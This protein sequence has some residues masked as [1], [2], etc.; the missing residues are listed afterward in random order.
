MKNL[1]TVALSLI[2]ILVTAFSVLLDFMSIS[3][4]TSLFTDLSYWANIASVNIAIMMII[5]VSRSLAKDRECK[6]YAE[7]K[8]LTESIRSAYKGLNDNRLNTA[9]KQYIQADNRARKLK[10]YTEK[11]NRKIYKKNQVLKR[12]ENAVRR[13]LIKSNVRDESKIKSRIDQV[14]RKT[15]EQLFELEERLNHA[16][17]DVEFLRV[18]GWTK[19]TYSVI[20]GGVEEKEKEEADLCTHESRSVAA[21]ALSKFAG[22]V[23]FGIVATSFIAFDV[24]AF[25]IFTVYKAIL[26]VLQIA[27]GIYTGYVAGQTFIRQNLCGKLRKRLDYVRVFSEGQAKEGKTWIDSNAP[28]QIS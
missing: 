11:L 9:L 27:L 6:T 20:F 12:K 10:V 22:I 5:F 16:E 21:L 7:Y 3:Y 13:R 8:N 24:K 18:R 17:K 26:K 23:A 28:A 14:G 2:I 19:V 25:S 1:K 15:R 4:S